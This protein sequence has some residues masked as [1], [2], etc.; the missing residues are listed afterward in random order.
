MEVKRFDNFV[1]EKLHGPNSSRPSIDLRGE[2]GN[3]YA[4]LGMAQNLTKQLSKADPERYDWPKIQTEMMGGDY[5]N[6]IKVFDREFG[7]FVTLY[8]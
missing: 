1:N 2:G 5:E 8:R 7:A 3:A 4:I 6:L